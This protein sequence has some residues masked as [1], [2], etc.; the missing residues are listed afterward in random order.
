MAEKAKLLNIGITT[1]VF[2]ADRVEEA[3]G[4]MKSPFFD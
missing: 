4:A 2:A 3:S 1:R